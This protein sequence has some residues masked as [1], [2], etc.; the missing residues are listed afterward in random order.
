M[1]RPARL[2]ADG[3]PGVGSSNDDGAVA[4]V[5]AASLFMFLA[6]AAIAIDLGS[7]WE[8]KRD[9]NTDLDA[10]ALAG[11]RTLADAITEAPNRCAPGT[12]GTSSLNRD[13]RSEVRNLLAANGGEAEVADS[14]IEIDCDRRTVTVRGSQRSGTVFAGLLGVNAID[15]NAYAIAKAAPG[16][17]NLMPMTLCLRASAI[18]D[19][20]ASG[21]PEDFVRDLPYGGDNDACGDDPANYAWWPSD[22]DDVLQGFIRD[23]L[24]VEPTLPPSFSCDATGLPGGTPSATQDGFCIGYGANRPQ[25]LPLLDDIHGCGT[26]PAGR[27]AVVTFLVHDTSSCTDSCE[28]GAE[29]RPYAFLDAIVR[30]VVGTGD[31][32]RLRLELVDLRT[33][34]DQTVAQP[35]SSYLCSADGAP[36]GD[37]NCD[38]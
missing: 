28:E 38:P 10:A 1:R 13:V 7:A 4:V 30:G 14:D 21:E 12:T 9:L 20:I 3:W 33:G 22:S 17:S 2:R 36:R 35:S 5:V 23:G 8:T 16:E 11:A 6:F 15:P 32:R 37:P 19:F 18:Q 34:A 29:Y 31:A 27:C 25:L 24:P 26:G